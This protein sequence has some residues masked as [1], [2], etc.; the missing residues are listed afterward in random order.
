MG[1][2]FQISHKIIKSQD[3]NQSI[4][5]SLINLIIKIF[6][7]KFTF[8]MICKESNYVFQACSTFNLFSATNSTSKDLHQLI[9]TPNSVIRPLPELNSY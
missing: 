4:P 9:C 6:T 7:T 3:S 8:V 2:I 1:H 5:N